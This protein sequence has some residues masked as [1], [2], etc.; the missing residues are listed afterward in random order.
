VRGRATQLAAALLLSSLGVASASPASRGPLQDELDPILARSAFTSSLWAVEVRR[1]ADGALLYAANDAASVVPGSVLKLVSTATAID[2]LGPDATFST[3][4]ETNASLDSEGHLQGDLFLVGHGDPTLMARDGSN[5][6]SA[7]DR[8]ADAVFRAGVREVR[9]RVVGHDAVFS[10]ER[11]AVDWSWGDLMWYYGAEVA[12]LCF[13]NAT[14]QL[15]VKPGARVGDPIVVER[16]PDSRYY[17]VHIE[18]RTT[19]RRTRPDLRVERPLGSNVITLSGNYPLHLRPDNLLV[20]LEDPP[21]YASTVFSEMLAERG[22]KVDGGAVTEPSLP[23]DTHVVAGLASP[24]V[25]EI[26]KLINQPSDN[27]RA[28]MLLRSAARQLTGEGS[29]KA[30]IESMRL[31]LKR[32]DVHDQGFSLQDGCGLAP[33]N[34]VTARGIVALLRAMDRHRYGAFYRASL[35]MAGLEGTLKHR[36][37]G[38]AV[39]GRMRAKTGFLEHTYGLAG[40]LTTGRGEDVAFAIFLNHHTRGAGSAYSAIDD[41]CK[42]LVDH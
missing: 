1:L 16:K 33:T 37:R 22:V 30:G 32:M 11:R 29:E 10:G 13:N 27:L 36:F 19:G 23:P 42:R 6:D 2:A 25:S 26:L 35:P 7:L 20:S 18:A 21:L 3:T 8:L 4:V 39:A 5:S 38:T 34:L 41:I 40:Y 17:E 14:V 28:E 15:R 12:G 31:F 9:G 24:P